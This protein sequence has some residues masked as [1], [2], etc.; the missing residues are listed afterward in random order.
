[1]IHGSPRPFPFL[2]GRERPLRAMA[3]RADARCSAAGHRLQVRL[4]R[5][6]EDGGWSVLVLA[7]DDEPWREPR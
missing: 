2:S 7:G 5:R 1:M 3:E 6:W 4:A